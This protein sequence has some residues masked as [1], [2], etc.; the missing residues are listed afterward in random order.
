[1]R[2]KSLAALAALSVIAAPATAQAAAAP[3]AAQRVGAE[4]GGAS[5]LHGTTAWVL[6]AIALGLIVWG[7]IELTG[8]DEEDFPTS[9]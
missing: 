4:P 7:I 6:A 8:N 2:M 3:P 1:M 9:P 5:Q